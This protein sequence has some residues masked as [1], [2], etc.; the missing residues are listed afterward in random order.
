MQKTFSIERAQSY[1][2]FVPSGEGKHNSAELA[3]LPTAELERVWDR[4]FASRF[5][6][7][8]EEDAFMQ[9]MAESFR[10]RQ[11][12]SIGSGMGFH[13]IYYRKH[14]A[15]VTCCDIVPSNLEVIRRIGRIKD[16]PSIKTIATSN[17]AKEIFRG[18]FDVAFVYGSLMAM[19][20][21]DQRQLLAQVKKALRPNGRIVLMLYTWEFAKST[22]GW[23]SP[24]DFDP[25]VFARA[26]DPSV[27]EE[28]CPWGLGGTKRKC[29]ATI[30]Q[31]APRELGSGVCSPKI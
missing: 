27:A 23:A 5:L 11:V 12:L 19:P 17:S 24:E 7:Y 28:H 3:Q 15:H 14:G 22:C 25:L 29:S 10:G 6:R 18:P 8:P 16:L 2:R 26:S 1:W 9:V 20:S 30:E 31:P 4:A 13:E 21:D